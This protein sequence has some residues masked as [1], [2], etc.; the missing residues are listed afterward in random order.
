MQLSRWPVTTLLDS[1]RTPPAISLLF[2]WVGGRVGKNMWA[3]SLFFVFLCDSVTPT[4][5]FFFEH[6][7]CVLNVSSLYRLMCHVLKVANLKLF[8]RATSLGGTETL[9]EHRGTPP[10]AVLCGPLRPR[11]I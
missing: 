3:A 4:P 6:Q 7:C 10:F 11:V 8:K 1:L 5:L 9:I 2:G